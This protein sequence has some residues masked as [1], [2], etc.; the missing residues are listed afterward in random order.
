[1]FEHVAL[2]E[3]V[4][5][6]AAHDSD[7]ENDPYGADEIDAISAYER[8]I[9][10]AQA[11]QAAEIAALDK[12]RAA[13]I[14]LG[15]GDHSVSVIGEVAMARNISP[16]A[17]GTQYGFAIGLSR[18]PRVA[19]VFEYGDISEAAAR[20]VVREAVGL[21]REQGEKLDRRLA[22]QLPGLTSRKAGDLA[23]A[24]SISIDSEAARERSE[25]SRSNSFVSLFPESDGVAILQIRGPAEQMVAAYNALDCRATALR[26]SGDERT[27]GQIMTATLVERATGLS[28][29]S[30]VNVEIGLVMSVEALMHTDES[31]VLLDG[32][33]PIP[34]EIAHGLIGEA[35]RS[36]IRRLFTDTVD[37]H[38]VGRDSRRRRF[39]GPLARFIAGRDRRCRQPGCD[40]K[41]RQL[42]HIQ[43][44]AEGGVTVT[45]NGQGLCGR[46]HTIRH[47]PGWTVKAEGDEVAWRTPTG[48]R[49]RSTTPDL[50]PTARR[51]PGRLR[52]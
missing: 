49:Y 45:A 15:S 18:L 44:F 11:R 30:A 41:I 20:A 22:R 24:I 47:L 2:E 16:S 12:K 50:L 3:L 19:A 25:T 17:A 42:D 8:L 48:H 31:A 13:N 21:A 27:R 5:V 29:A 52:Q 38:L 35:E 4:G 33:G 9:R 28:R 51:S 43:P 36:F 23:R 1:M 10:V 34:P 40:S 14:K 46:S 32:F 37:G 39:D 6:L 26:S 7:P